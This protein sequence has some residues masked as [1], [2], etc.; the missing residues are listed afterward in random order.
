MLLRWDVENPG[1]TLTI[2]CPIPSWDG[3]EY[4]DTAALPTAESPGYKLLSGQTVVIH[5]T[6]PGEVPLLDRIFP[7]DDNGKVR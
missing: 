5:T 2:P 7:N 4:V 3:C 6:K 1:Q